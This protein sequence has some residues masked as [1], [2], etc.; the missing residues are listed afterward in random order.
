MSSMSSTSSKHRIERNAATT[1]T[2]Q[3]HEARQAQPMWA[4]THLVPPASS[5]IS[6]VEHV[7]PDLLQ[8]RS[9]Q[10]VVELCQELL[11]DFLHRRHMLW[12][13]ERAE[14]DDRLDI[15]TKSAL[16][17]RELDLHNHLRR[18]KRLAGRG[19]RGHDL[20]PQP[21]AVDLADGGDR[22]RGVVPAL[23]HFGERS[24]ELLLCR[25]ACLA[26]FELG[27]AVVLR[28]TQP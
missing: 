6:R 26:C 14:G 12:H 2:L 11:L 28:S 10:G 5:S 21:R 1:H 13:R 20:G 17:V 7:R 4:K 25:C 3:R 22:Q 15:S 9:L 8:V 24:A 23:K 19:E 18:L 16:D 27:R